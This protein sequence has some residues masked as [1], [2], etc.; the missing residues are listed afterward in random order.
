MIETVGSTIG[1]GRS[2]WIA[3]LAEIVG[4]VAPKTGPV[5][6][7]LK[8]LDEAAPWTTYILALVVVAGC[9]FGTAISFI[10]LQRLSHHPK[11]LRAMIKSTWPCLFPAVIGTLALWFFITSM[12]FRFHAVALG[13]DRVELIYFWPQPRITIQITD[14]EGVKF[15]PSLRMGGYIE[16]VTRENVFRSVSFRQT[17]VAHEIQDILTERLSTRRR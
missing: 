8:I 17:K 13:P 7:E 15:I 14:L 5:H 6:M 11:T 9:I 4:A 1:F 2:R 16:L 10:W 12:F 3:A